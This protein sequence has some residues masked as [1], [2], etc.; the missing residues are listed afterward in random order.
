MLRVCQNHDLMPLEYIKRRFEPDILI[1]RRLYYEEII[2]EI[3]QAK[4]IHNMLAG[5]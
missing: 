3:E 4:Q 2:S 1:L 5:G